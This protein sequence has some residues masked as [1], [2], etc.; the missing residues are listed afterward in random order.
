MPQ[1]K[2]RK[3]GEGIDF[4]TCRI[5][6]R[7]FRAISTYHLQKIHG[8]D[9]PRP[10]K[11]YM[12]RFGLMRLESLEALRRRIDRLCASLERSGRRWTRVRLLRLIRDRHRQRL[13]VNQNAFRRFLPSACVAAT[14]LFGGWDELLQASGLDPARIRL[15]RRWSPAAIIRTLRRLRREGADLSNRAVALRDPGLLAGALGRFGSWDAAL[16]SAGLDPDRIRKRLAWTPERILEE[17]RQLGKPVSTSAA[18]RIH[19]RLVSAAQR[20][21]GGWIPALKRAG[22]NTTWYPPR[23]TRERIRSELQIR[24]RRGEHVDSGYLAHHHSGLYQAIR[25]QY[26]TWECA[27]RAAGVR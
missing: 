23:W 16:R 21:F 7:E 14:K 27:L 25:R 3:G 20:H 8:W 19:S 26:R 15:R 11:A 17:I 10:G 24:A 1:A 13:S 6:G 18:R 4:M 2:R 5:C 12:R 9:M 22:F